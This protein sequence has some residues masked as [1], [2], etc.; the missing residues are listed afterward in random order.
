MLVDSCMEG[1]RDG[2][3]GDKAGNIGKEP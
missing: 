3:L 1:F 2:T